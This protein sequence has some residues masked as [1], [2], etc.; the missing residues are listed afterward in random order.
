MLKQDLVTQHVP[1]EKLTGIDEYASSIVSPKL[2]ELA[3][4]L[5]EKYGDHLDQARKNEVSIEVRYSLSKLAN[6]IDRGFNFELRIAPLTKKKNRNEDDEQSEAIQQ[7]VKSAANMQ[8]LSQKG[9]PVLFLP[10]SD[11]PQEM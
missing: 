10:D 5:M 6:R 4:E 9:E 7:I 3:N 11:P 2:D 1:E 8:H